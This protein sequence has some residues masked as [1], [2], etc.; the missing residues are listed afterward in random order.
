MIPSSVDSTIQQVTVS[1]QNT[2]VGN[3]L[4]LSC[5][6]VNQGNDKASSSTVGFY[7]STNQVFDGSNV[8]LAMNPGGQ[9]VAN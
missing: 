9:L 2:A 4:S 8:L 5:S 3:P 7:L 1:P 6:I